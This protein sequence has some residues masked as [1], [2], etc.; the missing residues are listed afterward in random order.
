MWPAQYSCRAVEGHVFE[1]VDDPVQ[2]GIAGPCF[3]GQGQGPGHLAKDPSRATHWLCP[4]MS[5]LQ[6][7]EEESDPTQRRTVRTKWVTRVKV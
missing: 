3:Q 5:C 2:D 7:A 4:P 6:I 1:G